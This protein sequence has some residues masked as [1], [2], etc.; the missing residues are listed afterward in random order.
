M[1][2]VSLS[3]REGL[4]AFLAALCLF[5]SGI[6]YAIPKPLPF[7]R[8]GLANLPIILSL[9]ILRRRES[10]L[11]AALKILGQA[12]ISGTLF[13]YVVLF[14]TAGTF[15]SLLVMMGLF[16]IFCEKP[17]Q[18]EK[19]PLLSLLGI[20]VAGSLANNLAQLLLARFFLFGEGTRYIAPL[21][22]TVGMISGLIL[23]AFSL[24][25]SRKSSWYQT[26][27]SQSRE[28]LS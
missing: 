2:S 25:F 9:G 27:L 16:I 17:A 12:L 21:L 19:T 11:L 28:V 14:S 18:K 26:L 1:T 22:L 7:M 6:E 23:G 13:S 15:A 24:I 20:T 8:L 4:I 5:L 3:K 10:L